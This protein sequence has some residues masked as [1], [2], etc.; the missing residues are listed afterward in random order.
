[1]PA[2]VL[3]DAPFTLTDPTSS[4]T[5]AF[6]YTSGNTAV[7]TISG[8]VV[9]LIGVGTSVITAN[10]AAAGIYT[11]GSVTA[12]LVVSNPPPPTPAPTP[13]V[14]AA[15]V[16]SLFSNAYTNVTVDTWSAPWY[17]ANFEDITISGNDTKKYFDLNYAGIEF[18]SA[19]IDATSMQ[20]Y[21]V[22]IWTSD[23]S[24][25][26]I[27]LVDFGA[28]GIYGGSGSDDTEQQLDFNPALSG[29][30][31]YDIPLSDFTGLTSRAHLA[32]M[33]F[34]SSNSTVYADNI[35]FWKS[36]NAPTITG[37]SVPAHFVGDAPFTITPPT[38]N[39]LGA[40]S[41]SS[42]NPAVATVSGN[43]ITIIGVG[44]AIIT[45]TQAALGAY[46]SGSASASLVVTYR[47][48]TTAAPTPTKPAA[49]VIS[50]YSNAY[51]NVPVDTW[52]A[53]WD[54]AD[55]SETTIAGNDTKKYA[56][57]IVSGTE[58]TTTTVNATSMEYFH[59]DIWTPDATAFNIKLVDFGADGAYL[60]DD[61]S[62]QELSY[63][64]AV[65]GWV[66]YD[67]PFT[68]FTGLTSRAHLAQLLFVSSNSTVYVDNVYF[69]K[70][71]GTA[72]VTL[73]NF[74]AA[75]TGKTTDL[76]W[77]VANEFNNNGFA[78]ERSIDGNNWSE[79]QF[80]NSKGNTNIQ[81][82]YVAVDKTPVAGTNCYR[83]KQVDN[84]GRK[85]YSSI[86][87]VKFTDKEILNYTFYPNPAKDYINLVVNR[88]NT[89]YAKVQL[90]DV[91]GKVVREVMIK[92]SD[93]GLSITINTKG[94]AKGIYILK[95]A[96]GI[97]LN[98]AQIIID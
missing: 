77:I 7:A 35:Y 56:N 20:N 86:V 45:A 63:T 49:N 50:L 76:K 95:Y 36:P 30:V 39:S 81:R 71:G 32:Q 33:L 61:D 54:N 26:S 75:K 37:F 67:I 13:T 12:N 85:T 21:H 82:T 57:L 25:F 55:L 87:S 19:T 52:S 14:P 94:I 72:P 88:I 2:K 92:K 70:T 34:I 18:T 98:S 89:D 73:I 58:F 1:M 27:K 4:S 43:T 64:P 66:S 22:D 9:T 16:I 10:Q 97:Y 44:S 6:T 60:G 59:V 84:D 38:S 79:I 47:P 3:G 11:S 69:W 62:E 8:N 78:V 80:V 96:D 91:Q 74:T 83:L 29:W 53:S 31:S 51:T 65:N 68:D 90:L 40:F 93:A 41:Y 23:A 42:S 28:D 15:D 24:T 46:G 17:N 48:P 5:G